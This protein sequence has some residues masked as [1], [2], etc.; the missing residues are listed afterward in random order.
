MPSKSENRCYD[1]TRCPGPG[2][3]CELT[4]KPSRLSTS[5]FILADEFCK[6]CEAKILAE[7]EAEKEAAEE[8]A[9]AE[10]ANEGEEEQKDGDEKQR[11][12]RGQA[13]R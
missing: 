8:K 9:K 2:C 5:T 4:K 6:D 7:M 1:A 12:K 10:D 13:R 11:R 3:G